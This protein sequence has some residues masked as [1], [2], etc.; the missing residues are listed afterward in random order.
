MKVVCKIYCD[1]DVYK[2]FLIVTIIK[3]TN[4]VRPFY[5]KNA[6]PLSIKTS[7]V[8][9]NDCLTMTAMLFAWS[10]LVTNGLLSSTFLIYI[11]KAIR[12]PKS[13]IQSY[14]H[15]MYNIIFDKIIQQKYYIILEECRYK[16]LV[17]TLT[18]SWFCD[19]IYS[20]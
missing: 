8:S 2:R 14:R 3:T 10:L 16:A 13:T 7:A 18:N 9:K 15:I 17:F 11:K 4:D 5:P 19:I 12:F 1:I 20:S 6:F